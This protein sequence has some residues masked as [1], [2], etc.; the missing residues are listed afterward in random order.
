MLLDLDSMEGKG[1]EKKE[2]GGE[3]K[4]PACFCP[5]TFVQMTGKQ[6]RALKANSRKINLAE[7]KW[8]HEGMVEISIPSYLERTGRLQWGGSAALFA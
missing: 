6:I 4:K 3:K 1:K 5:S 7:S 2:G 8:L